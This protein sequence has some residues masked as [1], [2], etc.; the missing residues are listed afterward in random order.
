MPGPRASPRLERLSPV[1]PR[2]P[3]QT[4]GQLCG[5]WRDAS[6][7]GVWA[8]G[9]LTC[10]RSLLE[11]CS[12][13][14]AGSVPPLPT[15]GTAYVHGTF[16]VSTCGDRVNRV[17]ASALPLER[18]GVHAV[19]GTLTPAGAWTTGA[20]IQSQHK[21]RASLQASDT[22]K[23]VRKPAA[24]RQQTLSSAAGVLLSHLASATH[25]RPPAYISN[26]QA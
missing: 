15:P 17:R 19:S 1:L 6:P 24:S 14:A 9:W 21:S 20:P 25:D 12:S 22:I 10:A 7:G 3:E 8:E 23:D 11:P 4:S 5:P 26:T 2:L 13:P 18:G 16:Q